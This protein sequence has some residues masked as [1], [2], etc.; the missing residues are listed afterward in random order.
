ML[1]MDEHEELFTF[2][3]SSHKIMFKT[4]ELYIGNNGSTLKYVQNFILAAMD[5]H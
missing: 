1:F 5:P 2:A 3:L 4:A